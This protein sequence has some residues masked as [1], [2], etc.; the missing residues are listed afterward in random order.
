MDAP[1]LLTIPVELRELIYGFLFRS[2]TIRH[3]FKHPSMPGKDSEPS[4]RIALLLSCRQIF[5]E[6]NRHLPLNCTL[7]FRGTENLL[8]TL[9]S[10][11]QSVVTRLR[12]ARVR[13]FPFPLYPSG[14]SQYYPMYY[15]ANALTLFP[16]LCLDTLVVEDCWHGFGMG[17]GWRDVTTYFDIETLLKS[18]AWKELTYITPCTDFIASGYDHLRKRSAQPGTWDALIKERDGEEF[19]AQVKMYIVPYKQETA[20]G[21]ERTEDGRIMQP[22]A[23]KPGHEVNENWRI[24]GPEQDLKGEVRIIAKRGKRSRAVQLGLSQKT[25]WSEL[26]GKEAGGFAPEVSP[27]ALFLTLFAGLSIAQQYP[28]PV[29]YD[30]IIKSPINPDITISYKKVNSRTCATTSKW[31]KQYSGYINFPPLTLAPYQQNYPINTFFWFIEARNNPEK[32][33]LTIWLSGGPGWTSM[34]ELFQEIGPCKLVQNPDGT[35]RTEPRLWGWDRSSNIL[36]I[37]QP[38]QAGFSYNERVNASIDFSEDDPASLASRMQ[39]SPLPAD[40]PA[41]RFKNGTFASGLSSNTERLSAIAARSSWHFLQGFLSVFPQYNPRIRPGR[42][43][44]KSSAI[45]LFAESYGGTY[46]PIFA[47]YYEEQNGK[48]KQGTIPA[49]TLDIHLSSVGIINGILDVVIAATAALNFA[50]NNT[51][52]ISWV[53]QA[54]LQDAISGINS[55]GGCRDLAQQ[56]QNMVA[57]SDPEGFGDDADTNTVCATALNVCTFAAI[58]AYN[59]PRSIYDIRVKPE[60]SPGFAFSEYLNQANV[61]RALGAPVNFTS[62]SGAVLEAFYSRGDAVRGAQLSSLAGLLARGIRVAL[63]HGDADLICNWYGGQNYSLEIAKLVPGYKTSFPAAGYADIRVKNANVGGQVRQFGNLSFS[64]IY[65]A[66]H[67]APYYQQE[68]TFTIFTRVIQGRDVSTGRRVDLFKFRTK[69]PSTSQHLNVVPPE[70]AS[71]CWIREAADTCT[72]DERAAIAAGQGNVKAGIWTPEEGSTSTK[73]KRKTKTKTKEKKT[74]NHRGVEPTKP[75]VTEASVP[76]IDAFMAVSTPTIDKRS[77]AS[78]LAPSFPFRLPRF[79]VFV[80][81]AKEQKKQRKI[82]DGLL[83]GLAS[84]AAL[85]L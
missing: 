60:V 8:E 17:D 12:H 41:W 9:L 20:T 16:G 34:H 39:P 75:T 49:N 43:I 36:F 72:S 80:D 56:C 23:A 61:L 73:T 76:L 13:A 35:Y 58:A 22:W 65:D 55:E 83:G 10:V 45:N 63:I 67:Q 69:G 5:A 77:G 26:K 14:S 47:D 4:N 54:T 51:Y 78:T 32:A 50:H 1:N 7:H 15:A 62:S 84:A 46:G 79:V 38:T 42:T 59:V 68:T 70:P 48:R 85:F 74:K 19:G 18:D 11:D 81:A 52:G 64:R 57:L 29:T 40:T 31:Q 27:I 53:D 28:L 2:Y 82:R 71:V 33:P 24:A 21:D 6:A 30:R 3:G 66:G 44:V 25:T 37:D